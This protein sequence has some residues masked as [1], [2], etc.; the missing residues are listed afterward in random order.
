[1][2]YE[3]TGERRDSIMLSGRPRCTES[4]AV[5]TSF[6]TYGAGT[7]SYPESISCSNC[8]HVGAPVGKGQCSRC[9]AVW[10]RSC[11][12]VGL[13]VGKGVC[14]ECKH[15]VVGNS[16]AVTHGLRR[17]VDVGV[18][19]D[20]LREYLID[21][22]REV[23]EDLGGDDELSRIQL[24]L[25]DNLADLEAARLLLLDFALRQGS[26][27]KRGRAAL[28]D[29]GTTVERWGRV[30]KMLGLSRRPAALP[31]LRAYLEERSES[32]RD[33]ESDDPNDGRME[34]QDGQ[35][36]R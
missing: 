13:A 8:G 5:E 14:A 26:D 4:D 3:M 6:G 21:F 10:C 32:A 7:E 9:N 33:G 22:R 30:A 19:P 1:M 17:Y 31:S 27:T 34:T 18:L 28:S 2:G 12:H 16:G 15:W 20:D 11:G 35:N 24:G 29:H 23:S 36:E 25:I